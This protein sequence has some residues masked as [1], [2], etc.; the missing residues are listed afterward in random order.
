MLS[1][2]L[3]VGYLCDDFVQFVFFCY[4][5]DFVGE[6]VVEVQLMY[7]GIDNDVNFVEV[8]ELVEFVVIEVVVVDDFVVDCGDDCGVN[9]GFDVCDLMIY[10]FWVGDVDVQKG[11][12]F[13]WQVLGKGEDC[14][15]IFFVQ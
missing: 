12:V 1:F 11:Q 9:I 3:F 15:V 5:E 8:V 7:G 2:D 4:V 10:Y 13:L 14:V 6:Y